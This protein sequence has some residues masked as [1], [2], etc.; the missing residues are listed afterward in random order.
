[1]MSVPLHREAREGGCPIKIAVRRPCQRSSS[2]PHDTV[3][4]DGEV[5]ALLFPDVK[6]DL[7]ES[8][9]Q[10]DPRDFLSP[11]L[12]HRMKP[13]PQGP[14]PP[15]GLG[16]GEDQDPPQ[17][18]IA[19]LRDVAGANPPGTATDARGQA[20]VAGDPFGAGEARDVPELKDE[21]N[22][23]EGA[24]AGDGRQAPHARIRAPARDEVGIEASDLRIECGQQRPTILADP[25]RGLRQRQL[26]QLALAT[27]G[28]PALARSR[29]QVAASEHGVE[30]IADHAAQPDELNAVTDEFARLAQ[31]RRRNPD[32]GQQ[33]AAEQERETLGVDAIVLEAGRGNRL[34]LLGIR[35]HRLMAE[36]LKEIDEPP[37]V[38]DASIAMGVCGGS[39]EKKFVSR[40][41]SLGS[42]CWTISP[43]SVKT[44]ICELRLSRSTPTCTILLASCLR[45]VLPPPL[46]SQPIPGWAGGQR[47]Y[48][49]M[50][51]KGSKPADLPVEQPT[52]FELVIN[53]R[54]AKALGLTIPQSMLLRADQGIE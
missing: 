53:L 50:I 35:E 14:G 46:R 52:K 38:P 24:D 10:R 49:I 7:H 20:D 11:P 32:R 16:R 31:R 40:T 36:L 43:S 33:V 18:P 26:P 13:G 1:M 39:C 54:T 27:L 42:R 29:R 30:A 12:L 4:D 51:L 5:I 19:F 17:Q 15:D 21:H 41:A 48:D 34:R 37:P 3:T 2:P 47:A 9:R 28:Q 8:A 44:A 45:E 23:D 25:A 6:D 22:R